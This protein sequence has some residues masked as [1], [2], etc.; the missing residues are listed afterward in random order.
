VQAIFIS[1]GFEL[2]TS[3][4]GKIRIY[5]SPEMIDFNKKLKVIINGRKVFDGRVAMDRSFL[6]AQYRKEM[7]HQS[8]WVNALEFDIPAN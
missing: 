3:R 2:K 5:L 4:V 8:V 6:L 7:D 1:N